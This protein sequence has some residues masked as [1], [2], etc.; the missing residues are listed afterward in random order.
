M[1]SSS[2]I[3]KIF[4][5]I[6][7]VLTLVFLSRI[8]GVGPLAPKVAKEDICTS[9]EDVSKHVSDYLESGQ[10]GTLTVYIKDMQEN[11]LTKINMIQW[12][13]TPDGHLD[14]FLWET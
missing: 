10:E 9:M 12:V 11:D 13:T 2:K 5:L 8:T 1:K 3:N 14:W 7:I 6:I 4:I